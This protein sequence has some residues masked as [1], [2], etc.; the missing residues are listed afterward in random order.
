MYQERQIETSLRLNSNETIEIDSVSSHKKLKFAALSS[1]LNGSSVSEVI[2]DSIATGGL[3]PLEGMLVQR[4]QGG[5]RVFL[6]FQ[7]IFK[8][9]P[10][11]FLV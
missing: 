8:W 11:V 1:E 7:D 5:L 6:E 10:G 2:P 9:F 4:F 3:T